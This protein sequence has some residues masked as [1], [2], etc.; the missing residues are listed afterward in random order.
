VE[1]GDS[2][3]SKLNGK[4]SGILDEIT[5]NLSFIPEDNKLTESLKGYLQGYI[6]DQIDK[7]DDQIYIP[8]TSFLFKSNLEKEY[9]KSIDE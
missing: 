1:L 6:N 3:K 7:A 4:T 9:R 8:V 2:I 5:D